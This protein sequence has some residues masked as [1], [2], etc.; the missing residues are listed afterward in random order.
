MN[1]CLICPSWGPCK[2]TG[3]PVTVAALPVASRELTTA[4]KSIAASST[5]KR[6][7]I[8]AKG[9]EGER[10][11]AKTLN[12]IIQKC[13]RAVGGF[14][15]LQIQ[16]AEKCVQRNQNQSAVGGNDLSHTFGMSLEVKRQ[17]ALSI[18]TWWKQ[19]CEAAAPNNELPVLVYRQNH[20]AWNVVTL[21][22]LHLPGDVD[23]SYAVYNCRL[24]ID[25]NTFQSWFEQWVT[26]KLNNGELPRGVK[27]C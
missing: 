21:G 5:G 26:R 8:R 12:S 24:Q 2:C 3:G 6:I 13:M 27:A 25:W 7:D 22:S 4:L 17:E 18:N 14:T 19:C 1:G 10:Q 20:G 15:E 16:E 9:A 23:S 11:V